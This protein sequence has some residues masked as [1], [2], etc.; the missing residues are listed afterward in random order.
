MFRTQVF[1]GL[2]ISSGFLYSLSFLFSKWGWSNCRVRTDLKPHL[3]P[4]LFIFGQHSKR[5]YETWDHAWWPWFILSPFNENKLKISTKFYKPPMC[6]NTPYP[7]LILILVNVDIWIRSQ[8]RSTYILMCLYYLKRASEHLE[9]TVSFCIKCST[10]ECDRMW[11]A[12]VWLK[13]LIWPNLV[14]HLDSENHT[15]LD[16]PTQSENWFS[17]LV[18]LQGTV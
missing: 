9:I 6:I 8:A 2:K 16:S 1:K 10:T 12:P 7:L 15:E 13:L 14:I 18:L 11:L 4:S 5:E 3:T 17:D